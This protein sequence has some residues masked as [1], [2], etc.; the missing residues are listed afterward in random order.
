MTF[1][2]KQDKTILKDIPCLRQKLIKSIQDKN[3]EKHNLAGR[4]S[5]LSPYTPPL[6]ARWPH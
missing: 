1:N 2:P 3:P 4:T 5:P 6:Q